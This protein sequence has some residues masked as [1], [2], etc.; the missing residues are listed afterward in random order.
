METSRDGVWS[1]SGEDAMKVVEAVGLEFFVFDFGRL[2]F[3]Q[4][5][6][7]RGYWFDG[8]LVTLMIF[9]LFYFLTFDL[10]LVL[11]LFRILSSL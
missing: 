5:D 2:S 10:R 7:L 8:F 4:T 11:F 6:G 3:G 1:S 9:Y